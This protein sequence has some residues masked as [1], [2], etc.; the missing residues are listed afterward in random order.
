MELS[1]LRIIIL[2]LGWPVLSIGSVFLLGKTWFFYRE[3][4]GSLF[5][6]LVVPSIL[7]WIITMYSL[8]IVATFY[9]ISD[10]QATL[11]IFPIFV[12]WFITMIIIT[13]VT[14]RWNKEAT[15]LHEFYNNL[16]I[17]VEERTQELKKA[18]KK[19]IEHEHQ[20]QKLKDEFLFV[21]THELKSPVNAIKWGLDAFFAEQEYLKNLPAPLLQILKNVYERN[22]HLVTLVERL[23][24]VAR[25]EEGVIKIK[26]E[27]VNVNEIATEI[28]HELSALADKSNVHLQQALEHPDMPLVLGDRALI[29]EVLLNLIN[30][31]IKYNRPQGNVSFDWIADSKAVYFSVEDTGI[32]IPITEVPHVFEKFHQAH[33]NHKTVVKGTGLGLYIAQ[34]LMNRMNGSIAVR[35]IEDKGTT[36]TVSFRVYTS[37]VTEAEEKK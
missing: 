36:F 23:L 1:T 2:V 28:I 7:G 13:I 37:P 34:A 10:L 19:D 4:K 24:D 12:I 31:A 21:A 20:I 14:L 15:K 17:Q 5:G 33:K 8:A 16:E 22:E 29:K 32:G 11:I 25:I 27:A 35:S 3:V 30:N 9:L 18:H 6:R 26:Q